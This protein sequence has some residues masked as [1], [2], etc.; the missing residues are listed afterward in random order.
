MSYQLIKPEFNSDTSITLWC[1]DS[2]FIKHKIKVL[3]FKSRFYVPADDPVPDSDHIIDVVEGFEGVYGEKLKEILCDNPL[4]VW[5]SK[6]QHGLRSKF[7][8]HWQADLPILRVFLIELGLT[9]GFTLKNESDVV[10]YTDII[11]SLSPT[12]KTLT[13][14][15]DIEVIAAGRFPDPDQATNPVTIISLWDNQ[16]KK[17]LQI[18]LDEFEKQEWKENDWL[19]IHTTDE[20]KLL[21]LTSQYFSRL[22]P[23]VITGWN[24]DFDIT[25]LTNRCIRKQ[26]PLTFE[27]SCIFNMIDG[28]AIIHKRLGNR[29]KEVAEED[30]LMDIYL[31]FKQ[32]YWSDPTLRHLGLQAN[33]SHVQ[34][35]VI[36]D[37]RRKIIPFFWGL[38]QFVGL[39]DMSGSTSHGI[40]IDTLFL[41]EAKGRYILPSSPERDMHKGNSARGFRG[42]IV[43]DTVPGIH[44][45]VGAYDMSRYYPNIVIGYKISPDSKGELGPNVCRRLMKEREKFESEMSKYEPGSPEYKLAKDKRDEVKYLLNSVWGYYGWSGSRVFEQ[46]K[47]AKVALK[48]R[49]GLLYLKFTAEKHGLQVLAGDTDSLFLKVGKM[50]SAKVTNMLNDALK[51]YS[52]KEGINVQLSLKLDHFY[53]KLLLTEAQKRSAGRVTWEN[54]KDCDYIEIKGWESIRRDSSHLTREVLP[55]VFDA[56]LKTGTGGLISYLEETA[57]KIKQNKFDVDYIAINKQLH[58]KDLAEPTLDFYTGSVF[59]NKH[60]GFDIRTGDMIKVLPVRMIYGCPNVNVLCYLDKEAVPWKRIVIDYDRIITRTLKNRVKDILSLAGLS[61]AEVEKTRNLKKVFG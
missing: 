61:W 46:P 45:E 5:D 57:Q 11:P 32:E 8:K 21:S 54:E 50:D 16:S 53:S 2:N 15:L 52:A 14:I 27:G 20:N 9:D 17:Y 37:E 1:R 36:E 23:D 42:A 44:E 7:T 39:E 47:A 58:K 24:V 51:E 29:L 41:R 19:I 49:E 18:I 40:L 26:I 3:G 25:Y 10:R 12:D 33:H 28:Y 56:V 38:K 31:E 13:C 4:S 55:K 43:L 6:K 30:K 35:L 22:Q 59:A 60:F 34:V 48:A